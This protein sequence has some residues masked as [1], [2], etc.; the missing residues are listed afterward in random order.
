[1][2]EDVL[3]APVPFRTPV[4]LRALGRALAR[5]GLAVTVVAAWIGLL[6]AAMPS[7]F[8]SDSW[9]AFVDGRYVARH[10]LPRSDALTY[11]TLGKSWTDQQWGAQLVLYFAA[12]VGGPR[13]AATLGVACV[14]LMLAAVVVVARRLGASPRSAAAGAIIPL[15][16]APWLAQLRTQTLVLPFFVVAFGLLAADARRPSRRTLL[17]LPLLVVWANLHGSAALAAGLTALYG[18]TLLVRKRWRGLAFAAAPLT[19]VASPYGLALVAYYR[20]MLLHPPLASVVQE[21][22]PVAVRAATV[23]FF[24]TAFLGTALWA[25]HRERLT[26]FERW[27]LPLLLAVA[28]AATRNAVWF[29]L[30]FAIALPRLLDA[31]RPAAEPPAAVGRANVAIASVAI[32]AAA[33]SFT[34]HATRPASWFDP[35]AP[36]AAMVSHAAGADGIVLADD[37]HADWLLWERPEL[38][39][40]VAYDVRF[41]LFSKLELQQIVGLDKLR[42]PQWLRCGRTMSVVT[43]HSESGRRALLSQ[44]VLN[45]GARLVVSTPAFGAYA[46]TPLG[47]P[48]GL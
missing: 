27:A 45:P 33:S 23:P 26:L 3:V 37:A 30:A 20:L 1:M 17:V 48:C 47:A 35:S 4:V 25:K 40:R 24:A 16:G 43:F 42:R 44:H 14:G 21:W 31:V 7:L 9:L 2:A 10:W 39:G 6:A 12:H 46:Q 41:E 38:A 34:A 28:L 32:A 36:A 13:A 29:E 18:A 8:V 19:L 11:W 5:E 22:Q 15:L